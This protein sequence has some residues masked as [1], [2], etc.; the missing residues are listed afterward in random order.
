LKIEPA[1]TLRQKRE[2]SNLF[3][4]SSFHKQKPALSHRLTKYIILA[5]SY[6]NWR[7]KNRLNF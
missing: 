5:P 3:W 6:S 2:N 1:F 7:Y 4:W